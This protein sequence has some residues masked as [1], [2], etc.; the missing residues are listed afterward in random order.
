MLHTGSHIRFLNTL[1]HGYGHFLHQIR[2]LTHIFKITSTQWVTLDINTR[3]QNHIL[4]AASCFLAKHLTALVST[5]RIPGSRHCTITGQIGYEVIGQVDREPTVPREL[6]TNPHR[7]IRGH[8]TGD[9]LVL[10]TTTAKKLK[11]MKHIR[12]LL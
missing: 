8:Q 7:S 4:A 2:V 3:C 12:F 11:A 6:I 9:S 1:Y 10:H 5:L